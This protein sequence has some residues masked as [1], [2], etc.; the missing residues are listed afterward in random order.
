MRRSASATAPTRSS[1]RCGRSGSARATRSSS[2]PTPSWRRSRRS[3]SPVRGRCSSTSTRTRCCSPPST[4]RRACTPRT[5]AV[6]VVHLYGQM[7][8]MDALVLVAAAARARTW[9][10]TRRRRTGPPGTA[11]R[12]A[13]S[14]S[15]GASASTPARTWGR[16][17][18]PG[19]SPPPTP[20]S[21][22]G[23][24]RCATT[25]ASR[26]SHYDHDLL[27]TNSRLDAF[28][29]VVLTAK[30][31]RLD[32]WNAMRRRLV[33]EYCTAIPEQAGTLVRRAP[34]QPRRA[35]TSRCSRSTTA[36]VSASGSP[37]WGS[38]RASTTRRRATSWRRTAAT[39]TARCP[40]SRR[41][42]RRLLSLPMHPH[43]EIDEVRYVA[44]RLCEITGA[45]V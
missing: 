43:L 16:S 25:A 22:P 15:P 39:P 33:A 32:R 8:D 37:G 31:D 19:R 24:G 9:S 27:G 28:Q 38:R 34:G 13:P 17:G 5:R 35:T 44:D 4:W 20:G 30:L 6:V 11:G 21:R 1:W 14:A 10:R 12:P 26:A 18:T 29:A 2:P 36:T 42:P 3:C 23:S 41:L 45:P 40:W 7:P